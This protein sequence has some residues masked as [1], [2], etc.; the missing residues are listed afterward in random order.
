VVP[1]IVKF[2]LVIA[3]KSEIRTIVLLDEIV[4]VIVGMVAQAFASIMACRKDP[5]PASLVLETTILHWLKQVLIDK[6]QN[7]IKY[8]FTNETIFIFD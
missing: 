4:K 5:A 7:K 8:N 3:G 6:E 2:A 1:F